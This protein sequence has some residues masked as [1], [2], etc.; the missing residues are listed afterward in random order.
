MRSQKQGVGRM[1]E[2]RVTKCSAQ[3][4]EVEFTK[5]Y[6][7]VGD[8]EFCSP[9]CLG[10][11][12]GQ[13]FD[14]SE[15]TAADSKLKVGVLG[16]TRPVAT[17]VPFVPQPQDQI[18]APKKNP[19]L[20][21][22]KLNRNIYK[23]QEVILLV[24]VTEDMPLRMLGVMR[25]VYIYTDKS[26]GLLLRPNM[27]GVKPSFGDVPK[28]IAI[29]ARPFRSRHKQGLIEEKQ[30][31]AKFEKTKRIFALKNAPV[32]GA[33]YGNPSTDNRSKR[34]FFIESMLLGGNA[35]EIVE[36]AD[37]MAHKSGIFKRGDITRSIPSNPANVRAQ[38]E[39]VKGIWSKQ[40]II[41]K[42]VEKDNVWR[43]ELVKR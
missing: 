33:S 32:Q 12:L 6:G 36:R 8:R 20:N 35:K 2:P 38:Y 11:I 41:G 14:F 3:E 5:P 34:F 22:L 29:A 17:A 43:V 31:Q 37:L 18:I 19:S 9:R 40:G 1:P 13:D 42:V 10:R 28:A 15:K 26:M 16:V 30:E 7:I 4:C 23:G 27:G 25:D 21:R 39:R 24:K